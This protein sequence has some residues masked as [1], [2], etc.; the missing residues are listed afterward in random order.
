VRA[1]AETALKTQ[2][3]PG[4]T[5][6][7][8]DILG[9]MKTAELIQKT[10]AETGQS[11]RAAAREIGVTSS[12]FNAWRVGLYVPDP[13]DKEIIAA[14]AAWSGLTKGDILRMILI[15]DEAMEIAAMIE[16]AYGESL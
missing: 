4:K 6:F 10:L 3:T 8:A 12:T 11:H 15:D 7:P 16:A 1:T 2:L 5:L 9:T 13:V 14:M